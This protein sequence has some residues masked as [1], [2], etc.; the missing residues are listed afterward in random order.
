MSE[1]F[2]SPESKPLF[3]RGEKKPIKFTLLKVLG[4][5]LSL[6]LIVEGA[7]FFIIIPCSAPVKVVF[8]GLK[9]A[10]PE[11]VHRLLGLSGS[12][13]WLACDSGTFIARLAV[14][15]LFEN[16]RVEKAFPDQVRITVVERVPV[17]ISLTEING[18]T[19]PVQIDKEGVVFR[20]NE[21]MPAGVMPL[22][23]GLEFDNPRPGMRLNSGLKSLME[24]IAALHTL[25]PV[26]LGY[27]S[28]IRIVPKSYGSYELLLYPVSTQV[29]V[30]TDSSLNEQSLKY[31]MVVL[32]VIQDFSD[33]VT[34]VDMRYGSI[35]YR[36]K[37]SLE[38]TVPKAL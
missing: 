15:P 38:L 18:E 26:Y 7:L 23:T 28:E 17:A 20:V 9:L 14:S 33:S 5:L 12:E 32:D 13:T 37:E 4:I 6:A 21:G 35:S 10:A 19:V 11:E 36:T 22:I 34:E 16:V 31:M 3:P 8:K 29:R 27:L 1:Y 30:R 25:N 24:Q 2:I